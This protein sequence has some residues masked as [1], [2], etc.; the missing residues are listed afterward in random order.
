MRPR[1]NARFWG[2]STKQTQAPVTVR[3]D[4]QMCRIFKAEEGPSG[5]D[6]ESSSC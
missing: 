3:Y 1:E 4:R 6:A 2:Q 5:D